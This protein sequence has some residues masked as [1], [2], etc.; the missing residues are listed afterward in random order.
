MN[1]EIGI[2]KMRGP[3]LSCQYTNPS[4]WEGLCISVIE[5]IEAQ[6]GPL[7]RKEKDSSTMKNLLSK[8]KDHID[9]K[10]NYI[11]CFTH[12]QI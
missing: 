6:R 2:N 3:D 4:L 9:M 11:Y 10:W 1:D 8:Y 5:H 12:H 7:N